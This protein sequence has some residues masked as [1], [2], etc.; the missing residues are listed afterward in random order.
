MIYDTSTLGTATNQITFN[1]DSGTI[2]YRLTDRYP[3]QRDLR[4]FDIPLPEGMG[5]ADYQTLIGRTNYVLEGKM[6]PNA[7]TDYST[8]S[9]ALRKL[10][11]LQIEQA[12]SGADQG[13]VPYKFADND[14]TPKQINLKV[15]YVDLRERSRNGLKLPFRL[16]C[17]IKYPVIVAQTQTSATIGDSTAT[18]SGSSNLPWILPKVVGKT[19]YSS[20]GTIINA[21]D[22]PTYPSIT[23]TGPINRPKVT[24]STTS[25][26]LE[27]DV[28][29]ASSSDSLIV[30]YDQDTVSITQAGNS[31]YDKLTSG[32][33]LFKIA[34]GTNNLTLTGSTVGSGANAT[35]SIQS[36][37][38]LS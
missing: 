37:W 19:S 34:S 16:Y 31:K 29:L 28:N 24:N 25:E 26:Y 3:I 23:I 11:N 17:K 32:S 13:Y 6:Y 10:A 20:N 1:D 15:L 7:E 33:K 12:D 18:V 8:G 5:V 14:G 36:A 35:I 9:K 27:V 30:T 4:Q 22:L 21:G 38:P 2:F